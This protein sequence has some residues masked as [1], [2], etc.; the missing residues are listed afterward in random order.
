MLAEL[1]SFPRED[2]S[3]YEVIYIDKLISHKK[4]KYET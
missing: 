3:S 2:F 1:F 4:R